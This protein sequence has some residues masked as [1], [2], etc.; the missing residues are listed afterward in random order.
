MKNANNKIETGILI[1][2][3][4]YKIIDIDNDEG[5]EQY[6][7]IKP[8]GTEYIVTY[9]GCGDGDENVNLWECNCPA[10]QRGKMCKHVRMAANYSQDEY[11]EDDMEII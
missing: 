5:R 10:G 2:G 8:N 1:T 4:G 7:V 9:M 6:R 3:N 11:D